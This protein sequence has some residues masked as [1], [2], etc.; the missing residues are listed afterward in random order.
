[1]GDFIEAIGLKQS[2]CYGMAEGRCIHFKVKSAEFEKQMI[3]KDLL[4]S[5]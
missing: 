5:R 3:Q 4:F 1:L 2:F